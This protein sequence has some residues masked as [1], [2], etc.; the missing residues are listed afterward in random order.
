[1]MSGQYMDHVKVER[2]QIL[3]KYATTLLFGVVWLIPSWYV[4][5]FNPEEFRDPF[6]C[7]CINLATGFLVLCLPYEDKPFTQLEDNFGS[8]P[9]LLLLTVNA[10][11]TLSA[12]FHSIDISDTSL[13]LGMVITLIQISSMVLYYEAWRMAVRP[14]ES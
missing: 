5:L 13:I 12:I 3:N 14:S 6:L 8:L 9:L 4:L 11:M 10:T 7:F 1:M 2:L